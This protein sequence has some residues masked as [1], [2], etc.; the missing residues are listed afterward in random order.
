MEGYEVAA[1]QSRGPNLVKMCGR[2]VT[3][4]RVGVTC[5]ELEN[6]PRVALPL[7]SRSVMAYLRDQGMGAQKITGVYLPP[8]AGETSEKLAILTDRKSEGW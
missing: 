7:N 2:V 5:T 8:K 4:A 1:E 3:L 6:A